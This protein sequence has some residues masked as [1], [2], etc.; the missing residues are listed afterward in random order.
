MSGTVLS[1][2]RPEGWL[3]DVLANADILFQVL[4][5]LNPREIVTFSGTSKAIHDAIEDN[6]VPWLRALHSIQILEC[7]KHLLLPKS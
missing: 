3:G 7:C 5:Y 4:E 2:A 1:G 6:R